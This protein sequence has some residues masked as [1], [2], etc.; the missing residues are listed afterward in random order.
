MNKEVQYF[1]IAENGSGRLCGGVTHSNGCTI[2][3]F[4][5]W[6]DKGNYRWARRFTSV[7]NAVQYAENNDMLNV[8]VIDG[9]G[10]VVYA[11]NNRSLDKAIT[12]VV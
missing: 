7:E 11:R 2:S 9:F 5:I 12:S 10:Q 4:P 1:Y 3:K 8:H 6:R